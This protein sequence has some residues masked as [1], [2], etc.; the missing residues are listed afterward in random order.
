MFDGG[1]GLG[2]FSELLRRLW[3]WFFPETYT[4]EGF[5]KELH[6]QMPLSDVLV[7]FEQTPRKSHVQKITRPSGRFVASKLSGEYTISCKVNEFWFRDYDIIVV[8]ENRKDYCIVLDLAS[9]QGSTTN[10]AKQTS[11]SPHDEHRA[12]KRMETKQEISNRHDSAYGPTEETPNSSELISPQSLDTDTR[13]DT[14]S[15]RP[16]YE[17]VQSDKS[18]IVRSIEVEIAISEP[19]ENLRSTGQEASL[20]LKANEEN[21]TERVESATS[22]QPHVFFWPIHF[23]QPQ[24]LCSNR[25][26]IWKPSPIKPNQVQHFGTSPGWSELRGAS[27]DRTIVERWRPVG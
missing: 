21:N 24:Q 18:N 26:A 12:E 6:S 17:D 7:A 14:D 4:V 1:A 23:R 20:L 19:T 25:L 13:M 2:L 11:H 10:E 22:T 5:V 27:L 9:F 15:Y 3:R 16:Q 8:D